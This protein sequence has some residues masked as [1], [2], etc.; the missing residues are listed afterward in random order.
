M[1]HHKTV[2]D[3]PT[4]H[5]IP[6]TLGCRYPHAVLAPSAIQALQSCERMI[7]ES[8][9]FA[10]R[11]L[12]D[13]F[14][15]E[16][17][18]RKLSFPLNEHTTPEDLV[19]LIQWFKGDSDIALVSDAGAPAVADPGA[20]AVR[21]AH[22]AGWNVQPHVG[23][24]SIL[25]ALMASGLNGQQFAFKGYLPRDRSIRDRLWREMKEGLQRRRETQIFMEPPYRNM[26][27][28]SECLDR[29]DLDQQM[30]IA[31]D[32]TL[33]TEWIRSQTVE[34]WKKGQQPDLDKRPCL[35]LIGQ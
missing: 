8:D 5:L 9:R 25:L 24:S 19:D 29:L 22:N 4:L 18:Q 7:V 3:M 13:A 6:N 28:F 23:P 35:F 20:A 30:C 10:R 2:N 33:E 27:A 12:K 17:P 1:A 34:E 16:S 11:L 14:P 21:M 32:L 26:Q 15:E 31:V